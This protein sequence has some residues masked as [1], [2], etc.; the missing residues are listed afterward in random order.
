MEQCPTHIKCHKMQNISVRKFKNWI[1]C[2]YKWISNCYENILVFWHNMPIL[3][4]T[5]YILNGNLEFEYLNLVLGI[6]AYHT[7]RHHDLETDSTL[8]AFM[9]FPSPSQ[10]VICVEQWC[11]LWCQPEQNAKQTVERHVI[12]DVLMFVWSHCNANF[13]QIMTHHC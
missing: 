3:F 13:T 10:R 11:L 8:L 2:S 5:E 6:L 9:G 4:D 12:W 1:A 7:W